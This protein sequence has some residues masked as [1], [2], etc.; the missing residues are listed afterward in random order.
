VSS[1]FLFLILMLFWLDKETKILGPAIAACVLHEV[2]HVLMA[3]I[4]GISVKYISLTIVGA[5]LYFWNEERI[6]YLQD[7]L[8]TA[9][10]PAASIFAARVAGEL[11]NFLLAGMC[12]G[13]GIFNL[14]P[15]LPLDG[16]RFLYLVLLNWSDGTWANIVV[17]TISL[18][19]VIMI[20]GIGVLVLLKYGN[21]TM[22][23]TA[24]W[25]LAGKLKI[26]TGK[27]KKCLQK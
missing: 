1:G 27:R 24:C 2:G 4:F 13:Q 9:A 21:P 8:I 10:G 23:I 25:L 7:M 15:V 6:S 19:I 3:K 17:E 20:A 22:G 14:L 11:E 18:V 26:Y 5:E 16:G 12:L